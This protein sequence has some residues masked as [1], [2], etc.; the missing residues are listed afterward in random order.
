M[1][2]FASDIQDRKIAVG[3][4]AFVGGKAPNRKELERGMKQFCE[5]LELRGKRTGFEEITIGEFIRMLLSAERRDYIEDDGLY[6]SEFGMDFIDAY[7][8]RKHTE[9]MIPRPLTKKQALAEANRLLCGASFGPELERIFDPCAPK[10]F[11]GHPV[12]YAPGVE[13]PQAPLLH[14]GAV[15]GSPAPG[16]APVGETVLRPVLRPKSPFG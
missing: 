10:N 6:K 8:G 9:M 3:A 4:A 13:R 15:A 7:C 1:N 12:H 11:V 14:A 2:F 16:P 5:Q